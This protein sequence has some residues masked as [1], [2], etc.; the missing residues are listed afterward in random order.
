MTES[1]LITQCLQNDFVQL[2]D[3]YDPIPNQ[4]HVGY[5]EARRL[6]G[7]KIEEGPVNTVMQWAY[8][9]S[10]FS[11]K[12][13]HI[14]DWHD[15][16]DPLQKDHL[17]QFGEHCIK[18]TAGADFVFSNYIKPGR[19]HFI[20]NASGLND[21]VDTGLEEILKPHKGKKCRVGV[22]GVWTEAKIFFLCY[23]LKTRY[24][25]FEIAVCSLLTASSSRNAHFISLD[26]IQKILGI[27]ICTS[28]SEFTGFL[29]GSSVRLEHRIRGGEFV[30]IKKENEFIIT[31]TDRKILQYLF[32]DGKAASLKSLDG[33]FSGNLVLKAN[34]TDK[35]GHIQAPYVVKIGKREPISLER[36]SFEKIQEVLGN[37]APHIVDFAEFE[38]RA[39]IK[40]RY[41]SM[42]DGN[43]RTF[44]GYYGSGESQEKISHV[45]D[46]VFNKQLGRLYAAKEKEK[47]N[48]LQY[49][50]FQSKYS[51]GVRERV[52]KILGSD[53]SG[54]SIDLHGHKIPNVCRFYENDLK[55]LKERTSVPRFVSYVHG[56]LNGANIIVDSLENIWIIDFFHTH[57]G[58]ILKDLLKLENDIVFI[59]MKLETEDE[60]HEAVL[61]ID[62][63]IDVPDLWMMPEK[64]VRD[65]LKTDRIIRAF[66]T[67][68]LLRSYYPE[69]IETD[70]DPYQL[71]T[72]LM[73]YAMHTLSFDESS[74]WQKKLALYSGA[75]LSEKIGR[76]LRASGKLRIDWI[77]F[78]E[79]KEKGK[80][81]LTILP[82]R[83]DRDRDIDADIAT[84]KEHGITHVLTLVTRDELEYYGVSDLLENYSSAGIECRFFPILDQAV[85]TMESALPVLEWMEKVLSDGNLLIHCVGGLGRSGLMA[86]AY[87][88]HHYKFSWKRA[89]E[90]V[91]S[92]RSR[93]AIESR[94]QE[95][96][97]K[98]MS[99]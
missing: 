66:D 30:S 27:R 75:R 16:E 12:L 24:P 40:Y 55:T 88:I 62:A 81:G 60:F 45:L 57:E 39:G 96:F 3:K 79:R 28:L 5:E 53:P 20:V 43:V 26:S 15:R 71:Y 18:N 91:R 56:D 49:Y 41:A 65:R 92:C 14:R 95:D 58:H 98:K 47:L 32:R 59:F 37:N 48:L 17:N 68:S 52:T 67:V 84:V 63:L 29:N 6:L 7:E 80:M 89:F 97:L 90:T 13:I 51:P 74:L 76:V 85:P 42:L 46:T 19:E 21:F 44:Q 33:G 94:V 35:F 50:D 93:R 99:S 10:S 54:D 4:L 9:E 34:V 11:L 82:G 2:L 1:I 70:R 61:L 38:D 87:L 72:G 78:Q 23:D 73:R 36:M 83:K 31:D 8:E 86:G 64:T 22:A 77:E 25:E 69:L